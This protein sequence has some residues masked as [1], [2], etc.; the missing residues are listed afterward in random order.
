MTRWRH[1]DGHGHCDGPCESPAGGRPKAHTCTGAAGFAEDA[2]EGRLQRD[3]LGPSERPRAETAEG[4]PCH[5]A[6]DFAP[7]FGH[8]RRWHG[9]CS[10]VENGAAERC[11][12]ADESDTD[13]QSETTASTADCWNRLRDKERVEG[14]LGLDEFGA[15]DVEF[16]DAFDPKTVVARGYQRIVYGDH[17]PYIE[18]R[19]EQVVWESLPAVVLKPPHAYYDEYHSKGGEVHLYLQKR[20]VEHKLNPPTGGVRHNREGGYADYKIGMCYISPKVLTVAGATRTC[21]R[22]EAHRRWRK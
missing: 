15:P 1:G 7:A 22:S 12:Q 13:G 5:A 10:V 21:H 3:P 8:H 19:K 6:E 20:S 9:H 2:H 17:G 11:P 4:G 14:E 16:R 18:F